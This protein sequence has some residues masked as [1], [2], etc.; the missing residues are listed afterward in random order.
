MAF[1]DHSACELA[2]S[3]KPPNA[4]ATYVSLVDRRSPASAC[5][6]LH[7]HQYDCGSTR[8]LAGGRLRHVVEPIHQRRRWIAAG[9]KTRTQSNEPSNSRCKTESHR[10]CFLWRPQHRKPAAR[11]L[12]ELD[13]HEW[14]SQRPWSQLRLHKMRRRN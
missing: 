12:V 8:H 11:G 2:L 1:L 7:Q 10:S 9:A 3:G 6:K 14:R 13:R 5:S 4:R